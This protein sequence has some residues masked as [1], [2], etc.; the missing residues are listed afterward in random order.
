MK[1]LT[2]LLL[3]L[4]LLAGVTACGSIHPID[5]L[6]GGLSKEKNCQI[7]LTVEDIPLLGQISVT[8]QMDGNKQYRTG[9]LGMGEKYLETVGG[10][11]YQYTHI[12]GD[13]WVKTQI[14]QDKEAGKFE[15]L[16]QQA[17]EIFVKENFKK[18]KGENLTYRQRSD[19]TFDSFQDV[20]VRFE[21]D[22]CTVTGKVDMD[23]VQVS[24]K[25]LVNEIGQVSLTLPQVN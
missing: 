21:K 9:V 5:Q 24:V 3:T 8:V 11:T 23:G 15:E 16:M 4:C 6:R 7:I 13:K 2:T 12:L 10:T 19:V 1:K 17:Q 20:T 18:V 22:A 25:L 14:E